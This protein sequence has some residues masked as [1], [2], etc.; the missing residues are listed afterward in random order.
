MRTHRTQPAVRP[1]H[2]LLAFLAVALF[3][4]LGLLGMHLHDTAPAAPLRAEVPS[5]SS[6]EHQDASPGAE[7]SVLLGGVSET[8]AGGFAGGL[9]HLEV[10]TACMLA[11][12]ITMVLGAPRMW[13]VV[14][15]RVSSRTPGNSAFP[16]AATAAAPVASLRVL[17]SVSRT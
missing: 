15:R 13:R 1:V 8:G 7:G 6:I 11:L 17:L 16:R 14:A 9:G 12:L 4:L 5:V 2:G 3:V 10:V